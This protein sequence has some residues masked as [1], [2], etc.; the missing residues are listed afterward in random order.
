KVM[1]ALDRVYGD[2][3][4]YMAQKRAPDEE[5]LRI[6]GA[7]FGGDSFSLEQQ[8][9]G[10]VVKGAFDSATESGRREDRGGADPG[11]RAGLH[12]LRSGSRLLCDLQ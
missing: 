2:A 12:P 8:V 11:R 3:A 1:A 4:R 7:A 10:E 6:L 5:F 9:W